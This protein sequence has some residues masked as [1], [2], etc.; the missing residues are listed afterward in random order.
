MK[1]KQLL[2]I[3]IIA[4]TESLGFS[5]ILPYLPFYAKE[6]GATPIIV[7]LIGSWISKINSYDT[8]SQAS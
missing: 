6:L 5:L 7:G 4:L 2:T 3:L 1:N 8:S